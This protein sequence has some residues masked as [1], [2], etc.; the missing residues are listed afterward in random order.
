M[1]KIF[2]TG[3]G[4]D[5][6]KTVVSAVLTEALKA[7]YWKPMQT[8]DISDRKTVKC[9]VSNHKTKFHK[10]TYW[11]KE[12][13]SPH[14]AAELENQ[15]IMLETLELPKTKNNLIIEGAG[16]IMVPLNDQHTMLD[17]IDKFNAEVVVVASNYLGSI[18]H[19]LTTLEVIKQR[20]LNL[21]GV[22]FSGEKNEATESIIL[23]HSSVKLLGRVEQMNDIG[24]FSIANAAKRF[25]KI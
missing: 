10:E 17:V 1:R 13:A 18:N 6:G 8:G 19:T 21:L 2:V 9:L 14:Y 5:V 25:T 15:T 22:I 24:K 12:P 16:G 4:T 23:K 7:D 3:I 20:K 11:F